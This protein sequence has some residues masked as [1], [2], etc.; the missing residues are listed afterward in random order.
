MFNWSGGRMWSDF[1]E[2]GP[3]DNETWAQLQYE[4]TSLQMHVEDSILMMARQSL[5]KRRR[6][7]LILREEQS[8]FL[9]GVW[10]TMS[11]TAQRK[12]GL[13]FRRSL[14]Q[15]LHGFVT[16]VMIMSSTWSQPPMGQ[17]SSTRCSKLLATALLQTLM[18]VG[19]LVARSVGLPISM[20]Y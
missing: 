3:A 1:A 11:H 7:F 16:G 4:M 13:W 6:C 20:A 8:F 12:H 15:P 9:I 10:W 18:H 17:R 19:A 5:T 2:D 14:A